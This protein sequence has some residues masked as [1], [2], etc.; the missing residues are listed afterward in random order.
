MEDTDWLIKLARRHDLI[1]TG[2]S[3][4]HG[5]PGS[6]IELGSGFRGMKIPYRCVDEIN[7]ALQ[8]HG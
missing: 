5:D 4:F 6:N 2:G 7:S 8:K 3:D 1:V